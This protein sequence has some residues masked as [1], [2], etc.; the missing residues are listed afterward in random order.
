MLS[1]TSRTKDWASIGA[2]IIGFSLVALYFA[3]KYVS[4]LNGAT[5]TVLFL[6]IVAV[7][8]Y[9]SFSIFKRYKLTNTLT[10]NDLILYGGIIALLVIGTLKFGIFPKFSIASIASQNIASIFGVI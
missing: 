3:E 10:L 2:I 7:V 8:F 4:E 5:Q 9:A 1:T 6:L